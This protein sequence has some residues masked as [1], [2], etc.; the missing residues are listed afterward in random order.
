MR[1][2]RKAVPG[3]IYLPLSK[4]EPIINSNP[5]E[6]AN[7]AEIP[8]LVIIEN[9]SLLIQEIPVEYRF[10]RKEIPNIIES[11]KFPRL[12]F[13][14]HVGVGKKGQVCLESLARKIGYKVSDNENFIPDRN[15]WEGVGKHI[16]Y[17]QAPPQ[18]ETSL[19]INEAM[20][21]LK[22]RG[23]ENVELSA[24]AGLFLCEYTFFTS[25]A[26]VEDFKANKPVVLFLHI[27]P[28]GCPYS[29]KRLKKIVRDVVYY[30]SNKQP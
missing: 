7:P 6:F 30:L 1:S 11:I 18:L 16:V 23:I 3:S 5:K 19:N 2:L 20:K 24:D 12:D 27:P 29:K 14:L 8:P 22:G 4:E 28:L 9:L 17:I 10:V 21:W 25:M 15:E 13:I 26:V